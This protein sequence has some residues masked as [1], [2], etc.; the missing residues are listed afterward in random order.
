M[1]SIS[2]SVIKDKQ[3][4]R[5]TT[6]LKLHLNIWAQNYIWIF[7]CLLFCFMRFH[8]LLSMAV[9]LAEWNSA[10][11]LNKVSWNLQFKNLSS[12]LSVLHTLHWEDHDKFIKI[13]TAGMEVAS[14]RNWNI[15]FTEGVNKK[16]TKSISKIGFWNAKT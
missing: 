7:Y 13:V 1:L 12:I 14:P 6:S 9:K 15:M 16:W 5:G 8:F 3:P 11:C 2:E 4:V 10:S